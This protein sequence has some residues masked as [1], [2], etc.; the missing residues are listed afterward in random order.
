MDFLKA[1]VDNHQIIGDWD[2]DKVSGLT[3]EWFYKRWIDILDFRGD[4]QIRGLNIVLGRKVAIITASHD[5]RSGI[6][7]ADALLKKVWIEKNTYIGARS[8]LYNCHI[9]EGAIVACGAVVRN[10]DVPPYSIVE[11]NPARVIK[12]FKGGEW[13]KCLE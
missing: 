13:V 1:L 2:T 5:I 6:P 3:P 10:M 9:M 4:L 12:T 8:I 7:S 11:G